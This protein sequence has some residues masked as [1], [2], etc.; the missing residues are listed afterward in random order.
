MPCRKKGKP[1]GI[2]HYFY[3]GFGCVSI[4]LI[5]TL[6]YTI[7]HYVHYVHS[8]HSTVHFSVHS[9]ATSA[10]AATAQYT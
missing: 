7:V 10:A 3:G 1:N 5:N 6:P 4:F 8:V 2:D 9:T